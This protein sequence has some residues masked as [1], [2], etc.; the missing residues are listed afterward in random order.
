MRFRIPTEYNRLGLENI[1]KLKKK[2]PELIIGSSDHFN[3]ILSGPVAY[4]QGARVFEKHVTLNRG[5][6]GTDQS[7]A[8]EP[9]GFQ[10][11]L[12]I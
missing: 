12:E 6:K 3:G 4:L 10:N 2:Y 1:I 8:L 5:W 7:F 9:E 11:L